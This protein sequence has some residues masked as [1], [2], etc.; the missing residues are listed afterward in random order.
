MAYAKVTRADYEDYGEE[1]VDFAKRAAQ[2]ATAGEIGQLRQQVAGLQ[3]ALASTTRRNVLSEMRRRVPR[4]DEINNDPEFIRA[5]QAI[6]P[7]S[8]MKYQALLTEAWHNGDVD[9]A[10]RF[11]TDWEA[12]NNRSQA[13][14]NLPVQRG[15][16]GYLY[17][18]STPA[19]GKTI[20]KAFIDRFY[21]DSAHGKYKNREQERA[22]I[23][24]D[25]IEAGRTG[26][27]V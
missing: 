13:N 20:S 19:Q 5:L 25:I 9:R 8:G 12:D 27:I 10:A 16:D 17:R 3:S 11:F 21:L 14:R 15:Q 18:S 22:Q 23:E 1:F 4:F 24:R 2:D 6:E 7:L 26:R